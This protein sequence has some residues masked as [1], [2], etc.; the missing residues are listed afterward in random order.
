MDSQQKEGKD[1][2]YDAMVELDEGL[3]KKEK[4]T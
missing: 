2:N 4:K 1:P 3:L